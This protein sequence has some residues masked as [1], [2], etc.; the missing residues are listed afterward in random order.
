MK[1]EPGRP[2]EAGSAAGT[3]VSAALAAAEG[4]LH[5]GRRGCALRRRDGGRRACDRDTGEELAAI[6][7]HRFHEG[8]PFAGLEHDPEKWKPVFGKDHAPR[9]SKAATSSGMDTMAHGTIVAPIAP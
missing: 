4:K 7:L 1:S 8:L 6:D 3:K 5:G 2:A 9:R